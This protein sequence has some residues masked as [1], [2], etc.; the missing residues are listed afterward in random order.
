M[1]ATFRRKASLNDDVTPAS[2]TPRMF[3]ELTFRAGFDSFLDHGTIG[4]DFASLC[5]VIDCVRSREHE[6]DRHASDGYLSNSFWAR[7][8]TPHFRPLMLVPLKPDIFSFRAWCVLDD[9]LSCQIRLKETQAHNG[10]TFRLPE[11]RLRSSNNPRSV[12]LWR[13]ST[14]RGDFWK[15]FVCTNSEIN[16]L[17]PLAQ[18]RVV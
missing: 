9:R 12:L 17:E 6:V 11:S 3:H 2:Q 4:H 16:L 14:D 8:T 5:T 7:T 18:L 10:N 15:T 1:R 13:S